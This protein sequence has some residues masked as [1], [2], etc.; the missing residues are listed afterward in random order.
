MG[1]RAKTVFAIFLI[2]A[3]LLV[4]A[5]FGVVAA[6][7]LIA[8]PEMVF[9]SFAIIPISM[10]LGWCIYKK[11]FSLKL[12]ST[13]AIL[14][15]LVSV[16]IGFKTPVLLQ[17]EG[18][19]GLSPLLFWFVV[20][21]VYAG[22]ASILPVQTLLQPRDYLST[23]IL[24][25]SMALGIIALLWVAPGLNTP[26]WRGVMSDVQG[27]VWPMLFVLVACGAISGFHSLVAGG[28]TSKQ[29]ADETQGKAIA[30]G[31]MLTEG[32]VA[33]VTVLMVGGG[34]Y[35]IA[36]EGGGIDMARLGF[37]ET[38]KSGGW[39]LAFG[40]GYG[41]VV[42]QMLPILSFTLAS[43]IAVL[44]LNT[45]VLTTLDTAVRITRFLIQEALGQHVP[46]FRD[47][48]VVT[49][50]V[51]LAAYLIGATD[52]WQKIWPI[53]GATNQL[54]AAVALFV[55]ATW[56]MAVKR[57]T[58]YVLYPALFM[59][60]TTIAALGWQAYQFFTAK[61]TNIF[62]GT[63]SLLLIMLAIFVAYEAMQ[64][65]KGRRV[66]MNSVLDVPSNAE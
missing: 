56:L 37:R 32:V 1:Y 2:L 18:V 65:L 20:L 13:V 28:T 54:I 30:Y 46:I 57:P 48:Y 49:I 63:T 50:A 42:H 38:L 7:T 9:P 25:G 66:T 11:N 45:F 40:N 22:V 61:D 62:L 23:F 35:W 12:A 19:M 53:F 27:P 44:A 24:F 14:A 52:G 6:K 43:M 15:V 41:N 47:K 8:Q 60:V 39:I 10:I 17:D 64:S 3:M 33:V 31:G 36:P 29:L 34:L 51:V 4:I 59:V 55:V 16:Y 21:L 5:V 26:A 58:H